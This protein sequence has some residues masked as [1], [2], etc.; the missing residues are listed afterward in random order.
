MGLHCLPKLLLWDARL[1]WV[2]QWAYSADHKLVI[3]FLFFT[4]KETICIKCQSLFSG[5]NKKKLIPKC[6]L[7]KILPRVLSGRFLVV[8]INNHRLLCLLLHSE[9]NLLLCFRDMME[10]K[11]ILQLQVS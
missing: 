6:C 7:P 3:F 8:D 10:A 1:K 2:K 5:K 11:N 4:E 9:F